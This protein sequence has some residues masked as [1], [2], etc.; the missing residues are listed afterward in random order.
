MT[1]GVRTTTR[2]QKDP[3][4]DRALTEALHQLLV[5]MKPP[6]RPRDGVKWDP[7]THPIEWPGWPRVRVDVRMCHEDAP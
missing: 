6:R 7:V 5:T 3:Q 1:Q 2:R 4:R